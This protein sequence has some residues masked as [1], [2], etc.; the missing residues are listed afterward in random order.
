MNR[1]TL[2]ATRIELRILREIY[3]VFKNSMLQNIDIFLC[4]GAS[5][6]GKKSDR[7]LLRNEL[8]R[9]RDI[10]INYPEDL[11][12][13]LMTK[14]KNKYNLLELENLLADNSDYIIIVCESPGSF[15]ELGAFVNNERTSDKL[16]V[17]IRSKYKNDKSFIMQGPISYLSKKNKEN[18]IY[19]NTDVSE[20]EKRVINA[21]K[22]S[23]K[24]RKKK[25]AEENNTNVA[26]LTDKGINTILGQS[27][28][29]L[30]L[31]YFYE[32]LG[33]AELN[34]SVRKI[35]LEDGVK[36]SSLFVFFMSALGRLFKEGLIEKCEVREEAK[37]TLTSR[38]VEV[39]KRMIKQ[40]SS[41]GQGKI[42]NGIRL[43]IMRVQYR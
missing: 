34:E 38:G 42:I 4:G 26:L 23:I 41:K 39:V 21:I 33:F 3:E 10:T 12:A 25:K 43:D 8:E 28:Y 14:H 18:V 37:Y 22:L 16:I 1:G 13:E 31:L 5:K 35:N 15:A 40:A 24:T 36:D 20:M 19:Y 29:I 17:L 11:F 7:D 30:L 2:Q 6:A 27:R 32:A 9:Y